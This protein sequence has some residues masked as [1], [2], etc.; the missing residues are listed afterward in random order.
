MVRASAV[1]LAL[2]ALLAAPLVAA[3]ASG[4]GA[5]ELAQSG[6]AGVVEAPASTAMAK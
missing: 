6:A 3:I 5:L 2:A 4:L 1:G